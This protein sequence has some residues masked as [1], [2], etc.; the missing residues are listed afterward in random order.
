[1]SCNNHT[2]TDK[3]NQ[4]TREEIMKQETEPS[5]VTMHY[6]PGRVVVVKRTSFLIRTTFGLPESYPC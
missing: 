5:P 1:M 4:E 6:F 3:R 2:S